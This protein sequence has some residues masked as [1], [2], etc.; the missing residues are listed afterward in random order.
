V[1]LQNQ[2]HDYNPHIASSGLFWTVPIPEDNV[3][4]ELERGTAS[5]RATIRL[6]DDHDLLNSLRG[7][8]SVPATVSLEVHW[9]G[10]GQRVHLRNE[11]QG[12]T[13]T[14]VENTATIQWSARQDGF[15][16]HSAPA[17]TSVTSFALV[18]RERN[19][20][21]FQHG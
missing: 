17:D 11:E 6:F 4:F 21:F 7:G 3:R 2:V 15:E 12:F 18:G 20:V 8:S 9:G 5:M 16:F 10:D 1:G 14:Y 19:G 13:G